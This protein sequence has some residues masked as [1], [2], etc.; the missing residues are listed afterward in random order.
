MRVQRFSQLPVKVMNGARFDAVGHG[1]FG[2]IVIG[3]MMLVMLR[4]I[5]LPK[6]DAVIHAFGQKAGQHHDK[7]ELQQVQQVAEQDAEKAPFLVIF[8]DAREKLVQVLH[9]I[10]VSR[11]GRF[12]RLKRHRARHILVVKATDLLI[13]SLVV[14]TFAEHDPYLFVPPVSLKDIY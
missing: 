14:T 4:R 9:V 7:D 13:V 12:G 2:M 11:F 5:F 8:V 1:D 10:P 3:G 6:Q